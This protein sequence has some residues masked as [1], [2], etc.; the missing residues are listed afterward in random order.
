MRRSEP[1]VTAPVF[2]PLTAKVHLVNANTKLAKLISTALYAITNHTSDICLVSNI[3]QPPANN[4]STPAS[5]PGPPVVTATPSPVPP[6]DPTVVEAPFSPPDPPVVDDPPSPPPDRPVVSSSAPLRQ[7]GVAAT[8]RQ[9][10]HYAP[11]RLDEHVERATPLRSSTRLPGVK[12]LKGCAVAATSILMWDNCHILLPISS[13]D[14]NNREPLSTSRIEA[15][16][17]RGP[18]QSSKKGIK[19]LREEYADMM[20]KQQWTVLPAHLIK[21]HRGIR[22]S[23]L[24]LVP[25]R[26]RRE[27]P[28]T[29]SLVL[30]TKIFA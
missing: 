24:G 20:D 23:P 5:P 14:N 7:T 30:M 28:T 4:P 17:Q 21:G 25:Q 3:E 8:M 18:H 27:P 15:L 29:R 26:G 11:D 1:Q 16:L 13:A 12:L 2:S 19:F 6:P 10:H 9:R 22:L